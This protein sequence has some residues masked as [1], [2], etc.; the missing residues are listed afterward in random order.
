[1]QANTCSPT[2][3]PRKFSEDAR[4]ALRNREIGFVF[5]LPA[6]LPRASALENAEL[7]LAYAGVNGPVRRRR[8]REALER[9]GLGHRLNHW[10]QQLSGGEQQ[11]V[12]IARA[13]VNDPALILA[14][15]QPVRSIARRAMR[16]CPCSKSSI[17]IGAP[18]WS[19]PMRRMWLR[20]QIGAS[21][22]TTVT[23][24]TIRQS[25]V[26]RLF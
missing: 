1:M 3:K 24:S 23:S 19:S 21:R 20:W 15:S 8:A 7:P 14:E 2:A 18:L 22:Y 5:Q 25:L 12:A 10:P 9:V 11:R 16:S 17:A 4:A 6:L 13:F 26:A